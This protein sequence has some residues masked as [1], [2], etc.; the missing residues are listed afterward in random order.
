MRRVDSYIVEASARHGVDPVLI[1][2]TMHQESSFK[3][4]AHVAEGSERT[5]A[6][7]AG[8]GQ[9]VSA[10]RNIFDPRQNIEGGTRY[11]RFLLDIV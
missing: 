4:R 10:S 11:M 1:Y 5:D 6:I 2:A 7:D 8:N 9:R 3:Q